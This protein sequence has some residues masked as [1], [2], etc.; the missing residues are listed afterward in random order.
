MAITEFQNIELKKRVNEVNYFFS[1]LE[2]FYVFFDQKQSKT[3]KRKLEKNQ[4]NHSDFMIILKS[5]CYL[6]LYNLIE[7]T[8]RS[9]IQTVYDEITIQ[10][11]GYKDIRIELQ[12]IWINVSYDALGHTTTNFN[13]HKDK[14]K[15]MISF[16]INDERIVL[17]EKDINLN[18]NVDYRM[19]KDVFEKHGLGIPDNHG[20]K[21]GVGLKEIKDKR[22]AMAHGNI[23]FIDSARDTTLTD[24]TIYKSEVIDYLLQLNESVADFIETQN[25]KYQ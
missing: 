16:V 20:A 15:E 14:A 13:Q 10:R 18:G 12:K 9:L 4:Y 21:V 3:L 17:T 22:N 23:S 2:A 5:N 11:L 25:Y 8:V 1:C 19:I 6:M 7:S 24:L